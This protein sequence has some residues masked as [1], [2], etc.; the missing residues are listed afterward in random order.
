LKLR[1]PRKKDF[2]IVVLGEVNNPGR[3]PIT[4]NN[5]SLQEVIKRAGGIKNTASL[6]NSRLYTGIRHHTYSRKFIISMP[7]EAIILITFKSV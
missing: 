5:T 6:K 3:I 4:K 1:K 7:A 2:N